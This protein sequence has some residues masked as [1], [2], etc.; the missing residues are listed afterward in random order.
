M[1]RRFGERTASVVFVLVA[2]TSII[3]ASAT[4]YIRKNNPDE[5][6]IHIA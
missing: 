2:S 3:V 4:L 5:W 6:S 1:V